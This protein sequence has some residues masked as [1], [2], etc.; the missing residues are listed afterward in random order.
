MAKYHTEARAMSCTLQRVQ[1]ILEI[2]NSQL[3][4]HKAK[5]TSDGG[6]RQFNQ[7]QA[8]VKKRATAMSRLYQ[9]YDNTNE[10]SSEIVRMMR[11]L[12]AAKGP[13]SFSTEETRKRLLKFMPHFERLYDRFRDRSRELVSKSRRRPS[14]YD[15]SSDIA[16][17]T[18]RESSE[19]SGS[20]CSLSSSSTVEDLLPNPPITAEKQVITT[21]TI[22]TPPSPKSPTS[23]IS[24]CSNQSFNEPLSRFKPL[25]ISTAWP[26]HPTRSPPPVPDCTPAAT[27][28]IPVSPYDPVQ[29]P[30]VPRRSSRRLP[31]RTFNMTNT[32]ALPFPS[33]SFAGIEALAA[34]ARV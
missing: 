13:G 31:Y 22:S 24:T 4:A 26:P 7:L 27:P 20:G 23:S 14:N 29:A 34:T 25:A 2:L 15:T 21:T 10:I 11:K 3:A 30:A 9:R 17:D 18:S 6:K 5:C 8:E 1:N 12:G 28:M 16:S 33:R 19:S 32:Q